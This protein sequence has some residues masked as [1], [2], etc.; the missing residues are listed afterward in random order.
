ML[1]FVVV[2][3]AVANVV[4]TFGIVVADI[5]VAAIIV[6]DEVLLLILVFVLML[7]L[8]Y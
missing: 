4:A 6:E 8:M 1:S 7:V 2:A 5:S 3:A